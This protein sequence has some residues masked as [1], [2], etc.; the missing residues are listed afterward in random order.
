[1]RPEPKTCSRSRFSPVALLTSA[2]EPRNPVG[3]EPL[4]AR[5]SLLRRDVTAVSHASLRPLLR[6]KRSPGSH[7]FPEPSESPPSM[8][9]LAPVT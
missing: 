1:M 6:V 9:M 4:G 7:I 5:V 3:H 2:C 8:V